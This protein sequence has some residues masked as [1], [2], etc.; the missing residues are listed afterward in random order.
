[1]D[2]PSR[3]ATLAAALGIVGA[4]VFAV[5]PLSVQLGAANPFVG[6]RIFLLGA[7]LGLVALLLAS[8]GLWRT[9]AAAGRGG[10]GRALLGALLG[11][12]VIGVLLLAAG[13]AGDLPQ[14]NDITTNPDDPPIFTAA[15]R[16]PANRGRDM[17]YPGDEFAEQQRAAYEDL[18]PIR[19]PLPFRSSFPVRSSTTLM[20]VL[21]LVRM[22]RSLD[23]SLENANL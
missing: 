8:V 13:G 7:L 3:V 23:P 14:I 20:S 11:F 18:A 6:F 9:R 10:R 12:A 22:V 16:D 2:A 15:L 17:S 1:M 4:V 21:P 5:G 19:V